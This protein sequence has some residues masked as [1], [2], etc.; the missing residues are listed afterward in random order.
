MRSPTSTLVIDLA[1]LADLSAPHQRRALPHE[2]VQLRARCP[3]ARTRADEAAPTLL[4]RCA[5]RRLHTAPL[6]EEA[7]GRAVAQ[8]GVEPRWEMVT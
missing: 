8:F 6:A 2:L 3:A 4:R 7:L 5:A 1:A